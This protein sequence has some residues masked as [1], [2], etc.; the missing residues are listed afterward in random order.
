[1]NDT[2]EA[3]RSLPPAPHR[4]VPVSQC[5]LA[6]AAALLVGITAWWALQRLS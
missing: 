4:P 5:Y 2:A 3:E 6:Y 1:M